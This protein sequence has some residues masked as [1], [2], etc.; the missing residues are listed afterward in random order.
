MNIKTFFQS[1][2]ISKIILILSVLL[3]ILVV[4]QAGFLVGYNKGV[5][6]NNWSKNYMMRGPD[7]TRSFFAPF[8]HDDDDVNP[9]SAAG[10]IVSINLPTI[11]IKGPGR[12]EEI[13]IIGNDTTIRNF[14]QSASTSD[15]VV[16]KSVVVIGQ[17]NDKGQIN[18]SLVRII[19]IPKMASSSSST[20][21][22]SQ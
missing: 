19:P 4:F 12:A 16:G 22:Q 5:F 8:M 11:V 14:R 15:L 6:S 9:H 1:N 20:D 17:P 10:E 7:D 13:V 3:I 2:S 21:Q 18:A